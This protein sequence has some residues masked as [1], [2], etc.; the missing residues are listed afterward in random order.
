MKAD[1]I[2]EIYQ[3][4]FSQVQNWFF[5]KNYQQCYTFFRLTLYVTFNHIS[6]LKADAQKAIY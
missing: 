6:K 4:Y 1:K 3:Y 2:T 5:V